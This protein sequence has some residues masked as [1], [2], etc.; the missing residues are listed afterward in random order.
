MSKLGNFWKTVLAGGAGMAALAAVNASIQRKASEPDDKALGGEGRF[1][2][3]KHGRQLFLF[4]GSALVSR[5]LCG[6]RTSTR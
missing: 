4:M 5:V 3:W 1:F 6:E 2:P